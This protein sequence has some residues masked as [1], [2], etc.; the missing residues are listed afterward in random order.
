MFVHNLRLV[1][2]FELLKIET[3][4][5]AYTTNEALSVNQNVSRSLTL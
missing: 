2:T 4:Y 3:S 5:F 1:L